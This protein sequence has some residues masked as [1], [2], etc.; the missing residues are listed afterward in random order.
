MSKMQHETIMRAAAAAFAAAAVLVGAGA[1]AFA[2][3]DGWK[4]GRVY[5]RMVCTDCHKATAGRVISPNERTK[6]E[7]QAYFD[8]DRHDPSGRSEASVKFY[9]SVAYRQQIKNDNAAA[10]KFLDRADAEM[11]ADVVAFFIRGA[12]DSDT[13][14]TCQ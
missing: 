6:A 8:A 9:A 12:K 13:P 11:M 1:G 14:A 7:W 5:A 3:D 2:A 4:V 10:A